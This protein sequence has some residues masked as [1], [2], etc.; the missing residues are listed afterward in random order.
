MRPGHNHH[1]H[2]DCGVDVPCV[3]ETQ[4]VYLVFGI[5]LRRGTAKRQRCKGIQRVG[6]FTQRVSRGEHP[7]VSVL[8]RG[9]QC[10]AE[11][12][13]P[14]IDVSAGGDPKVLADHRRP[15]VCP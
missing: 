12:T 15:T 3:A 8:Q 2:D 11:S 4:C 1:D 7:M 9:R 13:G 10:H 6:E 5:L 14:I